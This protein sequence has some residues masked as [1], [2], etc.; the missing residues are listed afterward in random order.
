M[1]AKD[2]LITFAQ[3]SIVALIMEK[4]AFCVLGAII[5]AI[6]AWDHRKDHNSITSLNCVAI[7]MCLA[8]IKKPIFT[9]PSLVALAIAAESTNKTIW[10]TIRGET[11]GKSDENS[12]A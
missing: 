4:R 2:M 10:Q 5:C 6:R 3:C 12:R 7:A 8:A 9:I 1:K 11:N